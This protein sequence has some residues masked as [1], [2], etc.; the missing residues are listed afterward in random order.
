MID[1]FEM[2]THVICLFF[3]FW[4]VMVLH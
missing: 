3:Y 2:C 1:L 4:L